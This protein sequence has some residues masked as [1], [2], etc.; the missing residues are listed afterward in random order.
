[1]T[2]KAHFGILLVVLILGTIFLVRT[3]Q[4][5]VYVGTDSVEYIE[6]ARNLARGDGLTLRRAS[7]NTVP[8][9]LRPPFFSM[10][11]GV[12]ILVGADPLIFATFL[13]ILL[14]VI[15]IGMNMIAVYQITEDSWLTLGMSILLIGTP[16]VF[17]NFL[18]AMSEPVFLTTGFGAFL[19]LTNT[20]GSA[21]NRN[22]ILAGLLAGLAFLTRYIGVAFLV[23]GAMSLALLCLFTKRIR[24][25]SIAIFG[26]VCILPMLL[27]II[28]EMPFEVIRIETSIQGEGSLWNI[29]G[30]VRLFFINYVWS[31]LGFGSVFNSVAY[32]GKLFFVAF[33]FLLSSLSVYLGVLQRNRQGINPFVEDDGLLP[34]IMVLYAF[35][36]SAVLAFLASYLSNIH[37]PQALLN[38]RV[39]SPI[40]ISVLL[41]II[42]SLYY[43]IRS[44]FPSSYGVVICF[45][46]ILLH[47]YATIPQTLMV[48]REMR[49]NGGLYNSITWQSSGVIQ[50][51][52]G[53]D[54]DIEILSN[55]SEALQFYLDRP[56][57]ELLE[58]VGQYQTDLSESII[59]NDDAFGRTLKSGDMILVLFDTLYWQLE[60]Y[61]K[62]ETEARIEA[63]HSGLD[64]LY[65]DSHG[66]VYGITE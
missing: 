48:A 13:N 26:I 24:F 39:F 64:L 50:F 27:W 29:L 41:A 57:F 30:P 10:L 58:L 19:L 54:D 42:L 53:I 51:L 61:Y 47:L 38:D 65:T 59:E 52:K 32:R 44:V 66:S 40:G 9:Y 62:E 35:I 43:G 6:A 11:L 5:G 8:M 20:G 14:F 25:R 55:E 22:L 34:F 60:E 7:G 15:Y 49:K 23:S 63:L 46:P 36:V 45:I 17:T 56:T 1:L 21:S 31:I 2:K 37:Y 4:H 18:G 3:L 16:L 33:V 28:V 12:G